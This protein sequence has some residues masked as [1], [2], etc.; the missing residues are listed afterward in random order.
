MKKI[1]LGSTGLEVTRPAF[2]ALPIQRCT[3]E[4]AVKILR[5]AYESGINFFDTANAYSNSEE[6]IGIALS[7][8]RENIVISTKSMGKDKATVSQH[9]QMS[10][11]R[12]RTNYIDVFQFHMVTAP[13]DGTDPDGMYSAALEA[14]EK[15]YIKHI[16]ITTHR[17][18]LAFDFVNSGLFSTMQFPISYLSNEEELDLV[19]LCEKLDIGFIAMK[20]LAG[21]LLSDARP[22]HAFMETIPNIVPIWGIQTLD[23]L[24]EWVD[25]AK[26][27]PP[28]D[29]ELMG[30]IEKDRAE[31]TGAFCRGCGYCLP[32]P[33][34]IEIGT[35]MRMK[36]FIN[37]APWQQYMSSEWH[38]SM[39]RIENCIEC[40]QCMTKCP[41]SLN[42]PEILK[43]S[44]EFYDEFYKTHAHLVG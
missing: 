44:L 32:C 19:R 37:R 11:D 30:I 22:C 29:D 27:N 9:I 33:A 8:V 40:G 15:G 5:T 24:M 20:G 10:L 35:A 2:G 36:F 4:D 25:L 6:R 16:G 14:K 28:L 12:L 1:R 23:Q 26:N 39:H 18:N 43:G 3:T 38:E 7:D 31:L 17:L 34:D 42:I 13:L 41:Y 21:G